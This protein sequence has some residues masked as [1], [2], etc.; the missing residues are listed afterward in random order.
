MVNS[1]PTSYTTGSANPVKLAMNRVL[2]V[3]SEVAGVLLS[4][5]DV[6]EHAKYSYADS[7]HYHGALKRYYSS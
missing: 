3:G 6:K 5:V 4:R 7:G 1:R 2:D